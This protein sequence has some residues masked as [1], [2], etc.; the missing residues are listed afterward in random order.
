MINLKFV[1]LLLLFPLII[2]AQER[3]STASKNVSILPNPIK[4]PGLDRSRT[5]RLYLPPNYNESKSDYPVLYMHDGQNLFDDVTSYVG[6]W[7]VDEILDELY[8]NQGFELIVVGIDNGQEKR[9]SEL[10]PWENAQYGKAEGKEYMEF[11][12]DVVKPYIDKNYRTKSDREHTAIMGSSMGGLISHYAIYQYP[13]VFGK[14][15]IYS[16]SYWYARGAFDIVEEK[17]MRKD[18]RLY[19]FVGQKE[20]EM[21]VNPMNEMVEL[22]LE[23]GHPSKN[24]KS[25]ID[26]DGEHNEKTWRSDFKNALLWLFQ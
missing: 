22:V 5:I 21:M 26:P 18:A 9:M 23:K 8:E 1:F 11:I 17:P 4:M 13:E 25:K 7:G 6:E 20:G 19:F 16:P 15:G 10:S 12:V 3:K 24:L 14:A 2:F